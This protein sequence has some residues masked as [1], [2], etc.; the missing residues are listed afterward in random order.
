MSATILVLQIVC[1]LHTYTQYMLHCILRAITNS[2]CRL[3]L[4]ILSM[5]CV[6]T[7]STQSYK[8]QFFH[9]RWQQASCNEQFSWLTAVDGANHR[10]NSE[11]R[12]GSSSKLWYYVI[13]FITLSGLWCM[14]TKTL[15]IFNMKRLPH[16]WTIV[17]P[18]TSGSSSPGT[19]QL[20]RYENLS[21]WL[22]VEILLKILSAWHGGTNPET[23]LNNILKFQFAPHKSTSRLYYEDIIL[24]WKTNI[25]D[26]NVY[27]KFV[28]WKGRAIWNWQ[29]FT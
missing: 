5:F 7:L 6:R 29:H 8:N 17:L 21:T 13:K 24:F 16:V 9:S 27:I 18:S 20:D 10:C 19:L 14:N 3:T 1:L 28:V 15:D 12:H 23:T 26:R 2:V 25:C 4:L 11:S 22:A